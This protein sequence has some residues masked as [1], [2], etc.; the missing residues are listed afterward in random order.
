MVKPLVVI[1]Q[2]FVL[3]FDVTFASGKQKRGSKI[4]G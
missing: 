1:S 3:L 4:D 2:K